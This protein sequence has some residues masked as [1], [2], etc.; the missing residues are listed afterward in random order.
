MNNLSEGTKL[1]I[2]V[3]IGLIILAINTI[4]YNNSGYKKTRGRFIDSKRYTSREYDEE[5]CVYRDV[6]RYSYKYRYIVNGKEYDVWTK[7]N[8]SDSKPLLKTTSIYYKE[9]NPSDS[10]VAAEKRI[11]MYIGLAFLT[12]PITLYFICYRKT[13]SFFEA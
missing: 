1:L 3:V 10:S 5:A 12:S 13:G 11:L 4:W 2:L 9:D 7:N 8:N 6:T